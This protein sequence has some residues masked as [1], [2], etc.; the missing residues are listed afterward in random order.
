MDNEQGGVVANRTGSSFEQF[1]EDTIIRAGYTFVD[2]REFEPAIYL[3][4]PI[5]S[6][7]VPICD[8]IYETTIYCDFILYHPDRHPECLIIESKWQQ[9][10]GSVDEKYPYLVINIQER[11][12]F[13]TILI[14]DGGGYKPGAE[15]WLRDQVGGNLLNV[16]SM[17]QF[18]RWANGGRL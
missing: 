6:M 10:G 18:Q 2:K 14:L 1:I 13:P 3:R 8:S 5:Y 15:L 9:S 17:T 16:F 7:Q 4:Q 11:Y 12:P